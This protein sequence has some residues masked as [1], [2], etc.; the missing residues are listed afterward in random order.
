MSV[1][2]YRHK[3]ILLEKLLVA[4][5]AALLETEGS[6]LCSPQSATG[7]H[8]VPAETKPPADGSK[9]N[10]LTKSMKLSPSSEATN[11]PGTQEL[12]NIL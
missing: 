6:L 7:T 5:F 3:Y 2:N 8:S 12:T 9:A 4:Y 1:V 11:W 10:S